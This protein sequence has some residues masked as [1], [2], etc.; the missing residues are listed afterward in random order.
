[1]D[2]VEQDPV[3][4]AFGVHQERMPPPSSVNISLPHR[5]WIEEDAPG[6]EA[7][8]PS[9]PPA[10]QRKL[11]KLP[12][13]PKQKPPPPP[14]QQ[15]QQGSCPKP[16][17]SH[18]TTVRQA[19]AALEGA[20]QRSDLGGVGCQVEAL[21]TR[22]ACAAMTPAPA[23]VDKL[24]ARW[25]SGGN[26]AYGMDE[27]AALLACLTAVARSS[28]SAEAALLAEVVAALRKCAWHAAAELCNLEVL[29][30]LARVT[31]PCDWMRAC[32]E[33]LCDPFS[34][35]DKPPSLLQHLL[36]R[37]DPPAW[38]LARAMLGRNQ[39][40]LRGLAGNP[41]MRAI[42]AG[43]PA[44]LVV[45]IASATAMQQ[46]M[47]PEE[48]S[49]PVGWALLKGRLDVL[50]ELLMLISPQDAAVGDLP[51]LHHAASEGDLTAAQVLL[52]PSSRWLLVHDLEPSELINHVAMGVT[53]LYS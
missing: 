46:Q 4:H 41:T 43:A 28:R 7:V 23:V 52:D 16:P 37:A 3:R 2:E 17:P 1:M 12:Q 53:P 42:Q 26:K 24:E 25:R 44:D 29:A 34:T 11:P 15:Q 20:V 9:Q 19:L 31:L 6:P 18:A 21:L 45:E 27:S 22:E 33:T 30:K 13:P 8:A 48:G 5:A 51:P 39:G 49:T 14:Q 35:A 36:K 38:E 50:P 10:Q 40:M 32:W 47:E